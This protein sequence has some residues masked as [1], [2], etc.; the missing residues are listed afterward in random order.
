MNRPRQPVVAFMVCTL[1]ACGWASS[2]A[3]ATGGRVADL[4]NQGLSGAMVTL[5]KSPQVSGPAAMTVFS[6]EHGSFAFPPTAPAG[7]LSVRLLGYKQLD[8]S[9]PV[10][11]AAH[12]TL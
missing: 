7:T 2:A 1:W 8:S 4:N 5:T 10:A 11:A 9:L 6:D 12:A 3:A